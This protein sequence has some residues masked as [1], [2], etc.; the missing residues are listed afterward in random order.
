MENMQYAEELLREFLIFRG[1]TSTLQ[2]FDRELSTDI[3]RNFQVEKILDL[4][5]Q[6]YVPKYEADKLISLIHFFKRCFCSPS[7]TLFISTLKKLEVSILRYYII[8]ALQSGRQDKVVE[9]FQ[10]NTNYLFQNREDW[11]PWFAIPYL[12]NPSLDPQFRVY[13]SKEWFD[14]LHLSFRNFLSEVF[15]GTRIPALLKIS[16]EKNTV[17]TLKDGIKQLNNKLSELQALLETKEAEILH[18]RSLASS[19]QE[20]LIHKENN[21]ICDFSSE[22]STKDSLVS[23]VKDFHD[24]VSTSHNGVEKMSAMNSGVSPSSTNV[25]DR[26]CSVESTSVAETRVDFS[27]EEEFPEVK[28]SFQ[29]TFLGH[30]STISRCR[31]SA[32]GTNVASASVDGTV[33]IWTYDSATPTS[34]NATIYCGAEIMSLDWE[35]RSDRLLLI[36]TADGGIK[37]WNVDAKRVVCDLS[38]AA[39]FP[40]VLDL[41]CSPV[42]PI[43]VSAAASRW[44]GFH[45][46]D[47][48]GFASLTVWNMKTWKAMMVLPLGEDPPA[49]T[50]LCFNHNGKILAAAATDG[51]I[52]MF[53]MSAGLQITGWPAHDSA[54]TS[55]LF[56][57]DETSIFSLGSDGKIFEWSL[58]NQGQVLWSRDCS[59][60]CSAESLK[61][62]RHEMALDSSGRRLLVTSGS[63]RSPIYQMQGD[64]PGFRTL[65]HSGPITSV[66]WHPTLPIFVTGSADHSVRV[67]SMI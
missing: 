53:D 29:E 54:V 8:H 58:Q 17:K 28:V 21:T 66:D 11:M 32:S 60:Y 33:R 48:V 56:G 23:Q 41:K 14:A 10:A 5:F 38:T 19:V 35:C 55:L 18:L 47:R 64:M 49:I 2:T 27:G 1:F 44:K 62:C 42:E 43:F 34:R 63:V 59:R 61:M 39:E 50:S 6:V 37:A 36:G 67:T 25:P 9:F 40:S 13:F 24:S 7:E 22:A 4:V 12:T 15:N 31:F 3:G 52:H 65:P 57:P 46:L 30:T 16:T 51:M 26:S 20:T 45:K